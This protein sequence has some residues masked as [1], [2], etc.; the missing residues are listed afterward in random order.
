[1]VYEPIVDNKKFNEYEETHMKA[2][3]RSLMK[4]VPLLSRT[5]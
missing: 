5:N 1:M 4:C 3:V 2:V